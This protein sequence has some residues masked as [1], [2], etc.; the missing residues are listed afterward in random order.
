MTDSTVGTGQAA[1]VYQ[2]P[3]NIPS[4]Q[5]PLQNQ[6]DLPQGIPNAQQQAARQAPSPM[7]S[8]VSQP[9]AEPEK[10]PV[11]AATPAPVAPSTPAPVSGSTSDLVGELA[12][13][14][15]AKPAVMYIDNICTGAKVDMQRAFSKAVEFGDARLI[16]EAY[17][18]EKLGDNAAAVIAQATALFEYSAHK[19]QTAVQ[20]VYAAVGGE[21]VLRQAVQHFNQAASPEERAEVAYLMDSGN[22]ALM[23][24]AAQ[25]IVQ[26]GKQAGAVYSPQSQP[27]GKPSAARGLSKEEY[28]KAI[29]NPKLS[30]HEYEKLR[31]QRVLGRTQ[32]I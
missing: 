21:Q 14:P 23:Q 31:E 22:T 12:S 13:D 10:P 29:S 27:M 2:Q 19:A 18:S 15:Y 20:A 26:Y 24:R 16:D 4:Q 28:I 30:S 25:R 1:G 17:L 8:H 11:L 3:Q 32:G 6:Q 7:L 5:V 9:D